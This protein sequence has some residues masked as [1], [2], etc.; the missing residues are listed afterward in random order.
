MQKIENESGQIESLAKGKNG[1]TRSHK[2]LK[3][4]TSC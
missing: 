1:L 2:G 3:G 4:N